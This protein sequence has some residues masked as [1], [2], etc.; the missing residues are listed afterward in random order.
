MEENW[1]VNAKLRNKNVPQFHK[2][3]KKEIS[4]FAI[5]KHLG[6]RL[7]VMILYP[8][9]CSPNSFSHSK[10]WTYACSSGNIQSCYSLKVQ[11][12]EYVFPQQRQEEKQN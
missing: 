10:C 5:C 2:V 6:F 1:G 12:C 8:S 11:M 4:D 9:Q 7:L 3:L